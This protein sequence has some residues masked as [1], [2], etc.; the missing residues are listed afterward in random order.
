[1]SQCL[2]AFCP[3]KAEVLMVYHSPEFGSVTG[4]IF[5]YCKSHADRRVSNQRDSFTRL[6][7]RDDV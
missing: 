6:K 5:S 2:I 3:D 1:M 7:V 4:K